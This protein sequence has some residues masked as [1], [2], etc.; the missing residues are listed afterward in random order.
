M[1]F[2]D[3]GVLRLR[4]KGLNAFAANEYERAMNLRIPDG[5]LIVESMDGGDF[6]PTTAAGLKTLKEGAVVTVRKVEEVILE[7]QKGVAKK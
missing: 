2:N 7:I 3:G 6:R 5:V 4:G 1:S